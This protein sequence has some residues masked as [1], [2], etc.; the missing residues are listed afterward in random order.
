MIAY[1]RSMRWQVITPFLRT[2]NQQWMT[3]DIPNHQFNV[4]PARY[5]HDRFRRKASTRDWLDFHIQS[6]QAL[7]QSRR[8]DGFLTSFPPLATTTA[9]LKRL[10]RAQGP[11]VAWTFNMGNLYGG[12]RHFLA[13][14]ALT[15][16]DYFAVHSR[17]EVLAYSQWLK[18]PPERFHYVPMGRELIVPWLEEDFERPFIV[19]MG[20]ANRDWSTLLPALAALDYP[21]I[22]VTQK[23]KL[24]GLNIPPKVTI[25]SSL[26]LQQCHELSQRARI[27]VVPVDN[28]DTA[29]G[30]VTLVDAMMFG[31]AT[32][33]THCMGSEDY[34]SDGETGLLVPPKDVGALCTALE[35]LWN[36]PPLRERIGKSALCYAQNHLSKTAETTKLQ[37]VLDS[38]ESN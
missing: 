26:S 30:Q 32:I 11:L 22:I 37:E 12:L 3:D 25:Q 4:I 9:T 16:V 17:R 28:P 6:L 38:F 23:E 14:K 13:A 15:A 24:A 10:S 31:R 1:H 7:A 35:Q 21:A 2:T 8:T 36:D 18:I 19:A 33:A 29:S 27:N 20:T 5:Q 34:M